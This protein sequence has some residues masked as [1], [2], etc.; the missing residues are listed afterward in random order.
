MKF[1]TASLLTLC[2]V[3]A[4]CISDDPASESDDLAAPPATATPPTATGGTQDSGDAGG[5]AG[6]D[7]GTTAPPTS[8]GEAINTPPEAV[9]VAL[10]TT[11][12]VPADVVFHINASDADGDDLSWTLDVDGDGVAD[13]EGS[14]LPFNFTFS[15]TTPGNYTAVLNVTDGESFV[16]ATADVVAIE[17]GPT[18]PEPVVLSGS[19]Y[20]PT[21]S[22]LL[23]ECIQNGVD[24]NL[25]DLFPAGPGWNY[26]V[27]PADEVVVYWWS[28]GGF[29]SNG[30][31]AGVVPNG[32]DQVEIC[33]DP[34]AAAFDVTY[35][36]TLTHPGS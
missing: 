36:M 17:A 4:G 10:N 31:G 9:L 2:L 28:G 23:Y 35:T 20:V 16:N 25:H 24:G 34:T 18:G 27:E 30:D 7:N 11:I 3:L 15:F 6:G 22:G 33:L 32:V 29:D 21:V 1:I 13:S 5:S 12:E 19:G 8:D 14:T 26:V